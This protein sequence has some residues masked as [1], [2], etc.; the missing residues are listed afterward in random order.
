M[1]CVNHVY[2]KSI[3]ERVNFMSKNMMRWTLGLLAV[4]C[5]LAIAAPAGAEMMDS[6]DF[7][8]KYEMYLEPSDEDLDSPPNGVKD[9]TKNVKN[10]GTGSADPVTGILTMDGSGSASKK[11]GYT[12]D[13]DY[14]TWRL[15][16]NISPTNGWTFETRVK[17][18]SSIA[19]GFMFQCCADDGGTG[20]LAISSGG[21]HWGVDHVALGD[22]LNNAD[23]FHVFRV[24]QA[25]GTAVF[26][27]WRDGV[28][29]S[30]ALS[31]GYGTSLNRILFCDGGDMWGGVMEVDYLRFTGGAYAPI[32]EPGT[33]VLLATGLIGLLCYAWR[34]RK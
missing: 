23:A 27:V 8:W 13:G 3:L 9:F 34:K 12:N 10:G 22:Q 28:L 1:C 25:P 26:S 24:A 17:V 20:W 19:N 29:L 5:L 14:Q 7:T 33:L 16:P 4:G 11:I 32:P 15:D 31:S 18:T 30:D 2:K 21:Q 6:D